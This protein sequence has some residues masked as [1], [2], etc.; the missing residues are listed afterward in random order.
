MSV[1]AQLF[2]L[3]W[4]SKLVWGVQS[5][6]NIWKISEP[7][8][9]IFLICDMYFMQVKPILLQCCSPP[10][11]P[12]C[13][14]LSLRGLRK[15]WMM[16]FVFNKALHAMMPWVLEEILHSRFA[17]ED[18]LRLALLFCAESKTL[19]S[20]TDEYFS[21]N[22]LFALVLPVKVRG[23][24]SKNWPAFNLEWSQF[25]VRSLFKSWFICFSFQ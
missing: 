12:D 17:T 1:L 4:K 8:W 25:A 19:L 23:Q 18:S 11:N 10:L 9:I 2:T 7:Q 16:A 22:T 5:T 21:V 3:A 20:V 13:F 15:W 24:C 6:A 14:A